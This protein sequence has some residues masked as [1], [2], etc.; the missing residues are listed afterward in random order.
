MGVIPDGNRSGKPSARLFTSNHPN[1][2]LFKLLSGGRTMITM[3]EAARKKFLDTLDAESRS[4]QGLRITVSRG[5]TFNPEFALN[6]VTSEDEHDD[7]IILDVSELKIYLDPE[8]AKYLEGATVDFIETPEA[9]GFKVE[10]P[11]AAPPLPTGPL[12]EAV[13]KV[14]ERQINPGLAS[15]GGNVELV[16]LTEDVAYLQFMGGCQ[17]CGMAAVT[18]KQGVEKVLLSE[19]PGLKAVRDITDHDAGTAP[20]M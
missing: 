17:G 6:F 20:Y 19:V 9:S 18:M 7:D 12:A 16:T 4:G 10:A 5:G 15:H 3:T 13:T 11:N 14:L 1:R 8:S 2:T